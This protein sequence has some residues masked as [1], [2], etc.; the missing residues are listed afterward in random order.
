[1]S[2]AH[3]RIDPEDTVREIGFRPHG[4]QGDAEETDKTKLKALLLSQAL[5]AIENL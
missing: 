1:L 5:S 2:E 4:E 3:I